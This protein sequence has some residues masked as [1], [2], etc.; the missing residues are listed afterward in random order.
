MANKTTSITAN[1][2][3]GHHKFTLTVTET[4]T[5]KANNTSTISYSFE[6]TPIKIP[7]SID[8][9]WKWYNYTDPQRTVSYTFTING[10][11]FSG[12]IPNYDAMNA[13]TLK[14]GTQTVTHNTDGTKTLSFSFVVTDTT[15]ADY[16]SGNAS[17]S[18]TLALTA[19]EIE[20][21][22]TP[23]TGAAPIIT[24]SVVDVND[25]TYEL[26]GDR[27]RLIKYHSHAKATMEVEG[28]Y[29]A[30]INENLLIIRNGSKSGY[31]Y[32]CT[33]DFVESDTFTFFA[34]DERGY[35]GS[36]TVK[37]NIELVTSLLRSKGKSIR[38]NNGT[39]YTI[40]GNS[41]SKNGS[42]FTPVNIPNLFGSGLNGF[43]L[44]T[45]APKYNAKTNPT[46]YVNNN[47]VNIT[48]GDIHLTGV[49]DVNGLSNA[50]INKLPNTLIQ[51]LGRI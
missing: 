4:S 30:A 48:I 21:P 28:Q 20:K 18:G 39:S 17:K 29:G 9:A 25:D 32:S 19:F 46:A 44:N 12:T 47:G 1:G 34:E 3:K 40:S 8:N 24:A 50:I 37:A 31:G 41:F 42:I 23:V 14:S 49:Q 26:T 11:T 6:I 36:E 45:V 10:T 43:D 51:A 38:S 22:V 2:S 7:S 16:T 33:F 13:V 15:T 27:S 5:S 35:V